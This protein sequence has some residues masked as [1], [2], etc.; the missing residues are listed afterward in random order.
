[1]DLVSLS[2]LEFVFL[3]RV[4]RVSPHGSRFSSGL[5]IEFSS[6]MEGYSFSAWIS[7]LRQDWKL[8]FHPAWKD[9]VYPHESRSS[10]GM[11][12]VFSSRMKG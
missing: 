4:D 6:R 8:C 9:R 3:S 7:F 5:E 12:I 2:E 1:M 11:E 10:S